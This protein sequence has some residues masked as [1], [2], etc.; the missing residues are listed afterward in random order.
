MSVTDVLCCLTNCYQSPSSN[1]TKKGRTYGGCRGGLADLQLG[2]RSELMGVRSDFQHLPQEMD[3][4]KSEFASMQK[5]MDFMVAQMTQFFQ[6]ARQPRPETTA[7]SIDRQRKAVEAENSSAAGPATNAPGPSS[8]PHFH[9]SDQWPSPE[10]PH[11]RDYRPPRMELP[12]FSGDN[13]DGWI[14]RVKR[15]FLLNRMPE[16]HMLE[17]AIIGL[18]GDALSWFQWENQRRPITSWMALKTLLLL[19]FH[20]VAVG[21]TAEEWLSVVQETTVKDY[22]LKWETLASRVSGVPEH[23]LEGSFVK[24]L[25]EEIKG[26]LHILQPV[27]LAQIM[28]T[29]QR[30]EEGQQLLLSGPNVKVPAAKPT[31]GNTSFP[32]YPPFFSSRSLPPATSFGSSSTAPSSTT[33]AK[34]SPPIK[35]PQV[36]RLTEA[37]YQDKRARGVCFRCD[38]KFHRGHECEQ[39]TLQVMLIMDEE[40]SSPTLESPPATPDSSSEDTTEETLATL[41]LNSLVG[42]SS[43]HTMKLAGKIGQQ[44][45]TVLIDSGA[46]HNFISSGVVRAANIPLTETTCYGILLGTGRKVRAEGICSQATLDLATLQVVTD[47]LPLDLGGADVILGIKWLETLGNMQVNWRTMVMRFGIAGTLVTLQGD[48]TLCKSQISLKVMIRTVQNEGQGY[49]VQP[50][51][52]VQGD[53]EPAELGS[54]EEVAAVLQKHEEVFNMPAGLPPTRERE[55]AITLKE[56]VGPISFRPYRYAQ[57][58]KDEIERLMEEML[59]SGIVQPSTSPF[60][61]PVLLVKKKDGSWRF[62]VDYRA[63]NRETV[64]DK[65][66]ILVIDELLD[67]LHGATVF[68]KLDLKSGYHQIRVAA[69]DVEKT[70]FRTH[71]GHYEFLVMPFGLTNAPATFQALMNEVFRDFLRKFVLVFFDDILVYSPTL[72]AHVGHLELVHSRLRQHELYANRKKCLFGQPRVDYLGH[73]ISANGFSVD[74]SKLKV[75]QEWPIPKSLKALR[76]FLGLTG[77]YRKFVKGYGAIARPLTD[78]LRKEAFGWNAEAQDA[79]EKLKAAMCSVPVLALPDFSAPFVLEADASGAGLGA[80]LMQRQRPIAYYSQ[81]LS[82]RARTKSVYERELMAIV[83]YIQKWRPYL[84]GRKFLVRTDQRSLK[85]L[86]E[87]RL[88]ASEHQK[89][90]T[91]LL[92]Y[93][94]DIQYRLGLENK[95]VDA[96]SRVSHEGELAAISILT[97]MSMADLKAHVM[98]DPQLSKL[99]KEVQTGQAKE[100]YTYIHGC[101]KYRGRLVLPSSSPFIPI[102]LQEYHGSNI[103]GDSG[104]LK[105]FQRVASDLYWQGMRRDIQEFV[106]ACAICQQNKY[107]AQSPAGLL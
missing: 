70:A 40:D 58:Q 16:E 11:G 46:T 100:G 5:K 74:P 6:A 44:Q 96:L 55:H 48:P 20:T 36:R 2:F 12:L 29:T 47:F 63:L 88:V 66:P 8:H 84:L 37:E 34:L 79:F 54:Q 49:W 65:F 83:L 10:H 41:S 80:I 31:P 50:S 23:I 75:M 42:I 69:K 26:P 60:S 107:L 64:A 101:L 15:F 51:S 68:S 52:L 24:G 30:I 73:V 71:E 39:K 22:R 93:D 103:G 67:E 77:Y 86:L 87:Q 18:E 99:I 92:G 27:G 72:E 95:A 90:L 43:A 97:V 61:S 14:F 56:G 105:T 91:K 9:R 98:T 45:V 17:A 7:A 35:Q 19:R 3:T 38:K 1:G 4:L 25:K 94:F 33:G 76:G 53:I 85:F 13:P 81:I 82:Q 59:Q 57:V 89:W 104:V 32:R 28:E 102:L 78:Q 62:C 106:A 21:S